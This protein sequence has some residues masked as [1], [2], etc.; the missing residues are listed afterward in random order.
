[1]N[2]MVALSSKAPE[3]DHSMRS[4]RE[5]STVKR[6][7]PDTTMAAGFATG[8]YGSSSAGVG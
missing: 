7:R 6:A 4:R 1:M 5:V 2:A 3:S 8:S